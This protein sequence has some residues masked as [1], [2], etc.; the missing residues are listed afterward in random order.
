M[1]SL[2]P[3]GD[4]VV[5]YPQLEEGLSDVLVIP[6]TAQKSDPVWGTIVALGPKATGGDLKVGMTVLFAMYSGQEK[7]IW[8]GEQGEEKEIRI[9]EAGNIIAFIE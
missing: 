7:R 3:L 1:L 5:V 6:G 9:I 8:L 2:R 4:A